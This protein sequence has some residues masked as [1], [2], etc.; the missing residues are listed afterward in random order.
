MLFLLR[1]ITVSIDVALH[2]R[3]FASTLGCRTGIRI[4]DAR[5]R[6]C[7]GREILR[8]RRVQFSDVRRTGCLRNRATQAQIPDRRVLEV[9][10]VAE[11]LANREIGRASVGKECVSTCR[12]R[13]SPYNE[14]KNNNESGI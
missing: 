9:G 5:A 7:H 3:R 14:K 11:D 4:G 8:L 10:A 1:E 13:W 6:I 12:S 2:T